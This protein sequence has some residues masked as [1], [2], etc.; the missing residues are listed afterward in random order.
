MA[1]APTAEATD[2]PE[3]VLLYDQLSQLAP[4][5]VVLLNRALAL[6]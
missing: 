2:W 1:Q 3:I 6:A 5:P 4:W